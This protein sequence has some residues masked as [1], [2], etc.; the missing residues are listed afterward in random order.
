[1]DNVLVEAIDLLKRLPE[2]GVEKVLE[3][4]KELKKVCEKEKN[5]VFRHALTATGKMSYATG[6]RRASRLIY[7]VFVKR[8]LLRQQ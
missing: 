1:M 8:V 6:T 5:L 2:K 3:Y 4:M 7:A